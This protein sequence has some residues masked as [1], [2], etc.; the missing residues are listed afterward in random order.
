MISEAT[1]DRPVEESN[2][3]LKID[4]AY[5]QFKRSIFLSAED[6]RIDM[7]RRKAE[8]HLQRLADLKE[9]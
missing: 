3:A 6:S 4:R 9:I 5:D 7:M 2:I 1:S 8:W